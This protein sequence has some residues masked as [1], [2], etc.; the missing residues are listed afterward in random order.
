MKYSIIDFTK[1]I[2]NCNSVDELV[3]VKQLFKVDIDNYNQLE[4]TIVNTRVNIKL[5]SLN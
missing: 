1:I 4:Q 5:K 3:Q 2:N